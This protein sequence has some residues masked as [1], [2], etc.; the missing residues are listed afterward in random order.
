LPRLPR[1]CSVEGLIGW[2]ASPRAPR[3]AFFHEVGTIWQVLS[4]RVL[5]AVR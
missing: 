4:D 2:F 3:A 5:L 1:F